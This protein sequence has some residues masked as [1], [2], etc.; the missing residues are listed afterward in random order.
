MKTFRSLLLLVIGAIIGVALVIYVAGNLLTDSSSMMSEQMDDEQPL[1]WVAPMNPDF[2]QDKPGKSPM[3]M[4][5]VPVY[6]KKSSGKNEGS[7]TVRISPDVVNNLGVRITNVVRKTLQSDIKTVGYVQYDEDKLMH[8]HPR[9]E[10]WIEKLYVK[11]NGDPVKRGQALY[12]LYSPALVNAQEEYLIAL[13]RKNE[14]LIK[15]AEARLKALEISTGFIQNLKKT[16]QVKQFVPFYSPQSGVITKLNIRQGFYV[17]PDTSMMSIGVLNEVWVQAEIFER[18]SSQIKVGLAVTMTLAYIPGREWLGEVDY[19][20]P[21]LDPMT[22]T[23]RVRLRFIN[24]DNALK[25]NMFTQITI[26]SGSEQTALLLPRE[27]VIRTGDMDRVVLALGEGAFKSIAVETG[28]SDNDY[29]EILDGVNEGDTVV[30][31]AQFLIDSESSKTSD[32]KRIFHG[33]SSTEQVSVNATVNYLREQH[34]M[35]NVSHQAIP[36]WNRPEMTMNFSVD[37]AVDLSLI[38]QDMVVVI[39]ISHS[40]EGD[41]KVTSIK[42]LDGATEEH[43]EMRMKQ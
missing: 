10:G 25:P 7:G 11:A 26:H 31:S 29:I 39:Q 33:D 43:H 17:K 8:I 34:R 30:S 22:R 27:A 15:A 4:D 28:R 41:L 2:K 6:A 16:R 1:Y 5:L 3:G 12:S 19:I 18:Q 24:K 21:T 37:E 32:F 36:E 23:L 20:Y 13:Q 42:P 9:V 35:I 38:K 14:R 40:E